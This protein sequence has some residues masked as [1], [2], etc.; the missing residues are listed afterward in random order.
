MNPYIQTPIGLAP[1]VQKIE[2]I[3]SNADSYRRCGNQPKHFLINLDP[4]NGQSTVAA[5]VSDAFH[6]FRIRSFGGLDRFLEYRLDGTMSQLK[7]TLSDI[8]ACAVYTNEYEGVIAIDITGLASH[9]NETQVS[10]FLKNLP[11][12]GRH[13]TFLIFVPSV[14]GKNMIHLIEK[15]RLVLG[16]DL[17]MVKV[18]QY[19]QWDLAQIVKLL[20]DEAGIDLECSAEIDN[21]ILNVIRFTGA[22]N[23]KDAQQL[24]QAM[25]K[26]ASFDSFCPVL[27][28]DR[29]RAAFGIAE[30][31]EAV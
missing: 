4:G 25:A 24:V 18:S 14:P 12:I 7:A 22:V 10:V 26:G 20:L 3:C 9:L 17:E 15:V 19:T 2:D 28:P 13:A 21:C 11:A 29:I 1:L 6:A 31:K 5:Y 27:T 23:V 8:R 16:H 30:R